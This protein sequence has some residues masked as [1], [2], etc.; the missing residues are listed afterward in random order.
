VTH[1][2][3]F[4][5]FSRDIKGYQRISRGYQ[6]DI[7]GISRGYQGDIKGIARDIKGIVQIFLYWR[8]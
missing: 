4:S 8:R 1:I 2:C 5:S 7:K 3:S 6:G